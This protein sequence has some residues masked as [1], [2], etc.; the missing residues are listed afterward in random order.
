MSHSAIRITG[1]ADPSVNGDYYRGRKWAASPWR[2]ALQVA[3][4]PVYGLGALLIG[5]CAEPVTSAHLGPGAV[6][7]YAV[8]AGAYVVGA[9]VLVARILL[10]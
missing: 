6:A 3:S 1:A 2:D 4:A 8:A 7:I 9:G 10:R 5:I